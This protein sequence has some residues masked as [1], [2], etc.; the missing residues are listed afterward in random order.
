MGGGR[1]TNGMRAIL[2]STLAVVIAVI[3]TGP[4]A[5]SG[6][7]IIPAGVNGADGVVGG[8]GAEL[9]YAVLG[10]KH[11]VV[12][13]IS[14]ADGSIEQYRQLRGSWALPAVTVLGHNA[15]LSADGETLVLIAPYSGP[16]ANDTSFRVLDTS[17]LKTRER[18]NLDGTVSFDAISPDGKLLY[19]VQYADPR[20]PLDYRV[21][22]YDLAAGRFRPGDVVDPA[23]PNERMTGQPVSRQMS[24]DG[25]WA[26]TLYGGGEETFIH[27]LDTAKATA[28]CV[29]LDQFKPNELFNIRLDVDPAS[30]EITVLRGG[31]PA[32]TVDPAGFEVSPVSSRREAGAGPTAGAAGADWVA[33]LAI[34]GGLALLAA[35][36][37]ITARR[38]RRAAA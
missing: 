4:A 22:A 37:L 32:A 9:N 17:G 26:Y 5:A 2:A 33:L 30:G 3:S 29:D 23:K 10:F 36:A 28:V 20:D 11:S 24:P 19:L 6:G 7:P 14:T 13:R 27:A 34:G 25:R 16:H 18:L 31:R 8:P 21:R 1:R 35:T 12:E 15:G 38:R